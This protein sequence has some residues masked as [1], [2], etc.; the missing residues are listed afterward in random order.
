MGRRAL[1]WL[2]VVAAGGA[3]GCG[4]SGAVSGVAQVGREMRQMLSD[5]EQGSYT[6]ACEAF[7]LKSRYGMAVTAGVDGHESN[8]SCSDVFIVAG[9]LDNLG[10]G[11]AGQTLRRNAVRAGLANNVNLPDGEVHKLLRGIGTTPIS[12]VVNNVEIDGSTALYRGTVVARREGSRWLLEALG[13]TKTS[14]I[15]DR[16]GVE[17]KCGRS[18]TKE[19]QRL[20]DLLGA[21]LAG[22]VLSGAPHRELNRLLPLLFKQPKL[23]MLERAFEHSP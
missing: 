18:M 22:R 10:F 15:Q 9:T 12:T 17:R 13:R 3:A 8:S 21:V 11:L 23:L 20:C 1:W 2:A 14:Y 5:L 7:T 16:E 4:S 19:Y 6:A